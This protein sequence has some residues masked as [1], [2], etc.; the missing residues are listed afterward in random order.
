MN[1]RESYN[2]AA[3]Y[4]IF[5]TRAFKYDERL[6][7]PSNQELINLTDAENDRNL[8]FLPSREKQFET[9]RKRMSKAISILA[10]QKLPLEN[11]QGLKSLL[12]KL[13]GANNSNDISEIVKLGLD[14][15][16]PLIGK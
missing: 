10:K 12:S 5:L 1:N 2:N 9:I 8:S 3:G 7:S 13:E 15:S 16:R 4:E 6:S 11:V 14:Y